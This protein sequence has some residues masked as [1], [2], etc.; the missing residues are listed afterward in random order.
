M[1]R[2]VVIIDPMSALIRVADE[3]CPFICERCEST[4]N[5][6]QSNH[7]WKHPV[8]LCR[9]AAAGARQQGEDGAAIGLQLTALRDDLADLREASGRRAA[10]EKSKLDALE[11]GF[12]AH[13]R[14][15]DE[16]LVGIERM[17]QALLDKAGAV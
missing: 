13:Q 6:G 17:L 1:S 12:A 11:D 4:K 5:A 14:Q 9:P 3:W 2:Q 8:V 15:M 10:A 16:K 7:D